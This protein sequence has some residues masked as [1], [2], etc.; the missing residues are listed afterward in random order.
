MG[1]R[2]WRPIN[3]VPLEKLEYAFGHI[4][5]SSPYTPYSFYVRGTIPE[6]MEARKPG[7]IASEEIESPAKNRTASLGYLYKLCLRATHIIPLK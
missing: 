5:I 7:P 1:Q 3:L 4:Y 2:T 6:G